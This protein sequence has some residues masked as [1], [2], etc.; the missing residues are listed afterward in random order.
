MSAHEEGA[1][2]GRLPGGWLTAAGGVP[3]RLRVRPLEKMLKRIAAREHGHY[4]LAHAKYPDSGYSSLALLG[5]S[6][7]LRLRLTYEYRRDPG[8]M[9]TQ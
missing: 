6:L 8:T 9:E 4:L 7:W 2:T 1:Q 5:D 3:K